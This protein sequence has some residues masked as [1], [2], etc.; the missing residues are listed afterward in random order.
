MLFS[1][2]FVFVRSRSIQSNQNRRATERTNG[3]KYKSNL[4]LYFILQC[5]ADNCKV[6]EKKEQHTTPR[7]YIKANK[8]T[9]RAHR[10][11]VRMNETASVK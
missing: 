10:A 11:I 6:V 7:M 5:F 8:Y 1:S 4:L 2:I 3:R 9:Y